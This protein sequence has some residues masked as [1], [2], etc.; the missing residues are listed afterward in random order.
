MSDK[1]LPY[2]WVEATISE[3]AD[4][5]PKKIDAAPE[6]VAGFV[7]MSHAPTNFSDNLEFE[8]KYWNEIKKSYTNFR[9]HDV[10]V[11]KVTPCFENGK[12]AIVKGVPNKIG[13]GSSEFYV[14]RPAIQEMSSRFLF[15][16]VKSYKFLSEGAANMT[17]AVGL[18]R[19][20]RSFVETFPVLVPPL[21][22]QKA[23]ADKLDAL[24][25]QVEITKARLERIPEILKTFR[26]SVLAAAMSGKLTEEWRLEN[27]APESINFT[28]ETKNE[29]LQKGIREGKL[30]KDANVPYVPY[31]IPES[32]NWVRLGHL[33]LKI[34]DGA[35]N[36]PKV[37]ESGFPYLMAKGLTGGQLDFSENRFVSEDVH[38]ELYNKCQPEVGDL[39]VVNIGAGIGNNVLIDVDFEFSFKNI[40]I[41]KRPNYI[42]P[43][44]MQYYF[45]SAKQR[46]FQDQAKGGAQPFLSLTML[47][48]VPFALPPQCEQTEIVRRVE[49]LFAFADRIEQKAN[50]ALERV[51]NL[52]Q[53]IL[54]K[55]FRGELTTDWRA[56]NPELISGENSAEALLAK[57][58][59]AR[60]A[61]KPVKK[62][63]VRKK[64]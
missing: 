60:E 28:E 47:N 45:E 53:S 8:E 6:T 35:H 42:A 14:I 40:A 39:L 34:T 33:A 27:Q 41:V 52:T 24:L 37:L 13:A 17:G 50:V 64:S 22:E 12:A 58:K 56:A 51:N 48:D 63:S 55:A 32:W 36:T 16:I 10:L 7:P 25:A 1:Q 2:G 21:A 46:I 18:R 54:A 62:S 11:A 3:I 23:I 15:S 9:E 43:G 19:V 57:I 49:E 26:Q 44:Y 4:I 31:E 29:R 30:A 38:R 59:A 20:P 61:L 5:N